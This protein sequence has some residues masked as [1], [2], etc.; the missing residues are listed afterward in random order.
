[1][2]SN[3]QAM[4]VVAR[5]LEKLDLDGDSATIVE[6]STIERPLFWIFFYQSRKYLETGIFRYRLAGSGPIIVD[7]KTGQL[8]RCG[9]ADPVEKC[10]MDYEKRLAA[11]EY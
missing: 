6:S 11:D 3:E 10:I 5:E 1:M 2:L 4:A 8:F 7:K 9:A